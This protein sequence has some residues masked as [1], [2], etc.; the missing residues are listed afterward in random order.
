MEKGD[1]TTFQY[2]LP[3][4]VKRARCR[5]HSSTSTESFGR[6]KSIFSLS[7]QNISYCGDCSLVSSQSRGTAT[8]VRRGRYG[9]LPSIC[10]IRGGTWDQRVLRIEGL[11]VWIPKKWGLP[12][13]QPMSVN[14]LSYS[15]LS[16]PYPHTGRNAEV[17][18]YCNDQSF[19]YQ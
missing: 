18:R 15:D 19:Y 3:S 16:V 5:E 7:S 10:G 2:S 12:R 4:E 8:I 14:A 17:G 1:F 13:G 6:P 11:T 9:V